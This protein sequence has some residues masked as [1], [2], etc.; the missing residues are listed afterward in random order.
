[1]KKKKLQEGQKRGTNVELHLPL[2]D[3]RNE[4]GAVKK[5]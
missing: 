1:L 3:E 2:K 4:N 5:F